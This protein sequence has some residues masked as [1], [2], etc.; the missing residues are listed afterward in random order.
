MAM[1]NDKAFYSI[2][3]SINML[4]NAVL[5]SV[6]DYNSSINFSIGPQI[7]TSPY[8]NFPSAVIDTLQP[9]V[10]A[11]LYMLFLFP[12]VA[13]FSIHPLRETISNIKQ[14]QRMAGVSWIRYWGT[15]YIFDLGVFGFSILITM[16]SAIILDRYVGYRL[17]ETVEFCEH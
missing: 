1:Y 16:L 12:A 7:K 10:I 15:I 8:L 17:M 3:I 6:A 5:K 11:I 2:P 9:Y 14:L 4:S 13:L